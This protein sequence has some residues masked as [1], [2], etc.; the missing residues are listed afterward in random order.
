MTL[1]CKVVIP[2]RAITLLRRSS[3]SDRPSSGEKFFR[4][5]SSGEE[6]FDEETFSDESSG[7]KPSDEKPSGEKSVAT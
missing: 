6:T 4:E 1:K 3:F 5:E 7:E 2:L